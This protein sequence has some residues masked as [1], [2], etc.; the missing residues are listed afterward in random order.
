VSPNSPNPHRL[1]YFLLLALL[2]AAIGLSIAAI[3]VIRR[4]QPILKGRVVETLA[5]N[6]NAHVELDNLQVS[7]FRGL[8]VSGSGLRIFPPPDVAA[9]GSRSP[10]ISI[11]SFTFH[12]GLKGLFLKPMHVGTVHVQGLAIH[13]PPRD[14]RQPTSSSGPRPH[15]KIKIEAD[16][17]VC[18]NSSLVLETSKPGK[19]PKVFLLKHIVLGRFGPNTSW[20][21]DAQL[22]NAMPK[23]EIHAT[24]A[25]G[26]WNTE[27]PGDSPVQ[28]HYTFD[29]A[30]LNP[31]RGIGGILSS[32][33][34]FSG[35]LNKIAVQGAASV[36]GFSLDSANHPV[37]LATTFS[38]T[39]DGL[40]GDTYLHHVQ[41][42]LGRSGFTCSGKVVNIKGQG[43]LVDLDADI[44]AGRIQDFLQL[45]VK[46]Q[47]VLM[48]GILQ[49]RAHLHIPPGRQSVPQKIAMNEAFTLRQIHFSN[50]AW[51]D[52]VDELSARAQGN[53]KL[54]KP[55]A[56]LVQSQMTG[57]LRMAG[58]RL[59][60]TGLDYT[61]PGAAIQLE[62]IYTLDGKTFDF[63]G[64][65]RTQAKPS[66]MV[67]S[68]WQ[69]A[70]L[71]AVDPFL[72]KNGAGMQVPFKI[73]G[74]SGAP[75]FGLDFG[76]KDPDRTPPARPTHP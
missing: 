58:G 15:T 37:P 8:E 35:Q 25:F 56:P 23:G 18:D 61:L 48:T 70:L 74:T 27:S 75:K 57:R 33:G 34:D 45:A 2:V 53:P 55:G 59:D 73:T 13:I 44:P 65:I 42:R 7:V 67:T 76:H 43:H 9:A 24:G 60:F 51:Q 3:V 54:A 39:V 28:G 16:E 20:R 1:W 69:R 26:P 68:W 52:K 21:F 66:Q 14:L 31:I 40:T 17:I 46:T 4:A 50:R 22:T 12:T 72:A 38:A 29:H 62:G 19:D 6:F 64:N 11:Q 63:H 36:P 41:A 71:K 47:P 49:T 10:L 30:D 5:H 32:T